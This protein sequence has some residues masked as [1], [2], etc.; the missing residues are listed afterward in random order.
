[1][2]PFDDYRSQE[3]ASI[4]YDKDEKVFDQPKRAMYGIKKA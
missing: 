1:V 2:D 3:E 4:I